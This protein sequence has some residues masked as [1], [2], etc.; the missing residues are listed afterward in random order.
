MIELTRF[1][2]Q[3]FLLNA[4]IIEQVEALPDTTIT[5]MGGKKIVVLDK[6]DDVWQ[7]INQFYEQVGLMAVY[8][9]KAGDAGGS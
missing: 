6:Y 9:H 4:F 5:L 7:R 2:K 1:N 3:K 8:K